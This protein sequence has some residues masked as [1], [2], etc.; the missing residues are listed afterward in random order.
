MISHRGVFLYHYDFTFKIFFDKVH[1]GAYLI[2]RKEEITGRHNP[3]IF[4]IILAMYHSNQ[5]ADKF[6]DRFIY[7]KDIRILFLS[8]ISENTRNVTLIHRI[9]DVGM[10]WMC[11]SKWAIDDYFYKTSAHD[12]SSPLSILIARIIACALVRCLIFDLLYLGL[13]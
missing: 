1:G 7:A 8:V 13:K 9:N 2:L 6:Q 12:E 11:A 3:F 10:G 4:N 5:L